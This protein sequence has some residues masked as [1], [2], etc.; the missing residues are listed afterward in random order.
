MKRTIFD[1]STNTVHERTDGY[2]L[3]ALKECFP[4]E[5]LLEKKKIRNCLMHQ[6]GFN[7]E[8]NWHPYESTSIEVALQCIKETA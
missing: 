7:S 3:S 1:M 4:E 2:L 5:D 8:W 6:R